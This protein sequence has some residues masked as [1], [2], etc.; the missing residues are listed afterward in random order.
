[1]SDAQSIPLRV[2][3]IDMKSR[4]LDLVVPTYLPARDL[5][6]RVARDAG[7]QAYWPD[8]RR[9]RFWIRARGR[10]VGEDERLSDVG[11]IAHELVHLLPEPP[12]GSVMEQD[13][14]YPQTQGYPAS[15]TLTV[16]VGLLSVLAWSAGWGVALSAKPGLWALLLPGLGL[17]LLSCSLARHVL[18]GEGG[19]LSI[20]GLGLVVAV[21]MLVPAALV[22]AL[23]GLPVAE[24][25]PLI[26][27]GAL[28]SVLGV[29]LG[30]LAW[31]GPVEPLPAHAPKVQAS[32][33]QEQPQLQCAICGMGVTQDV[34]VGCQHRCGRA[35]HK[36]CYQARMSVA[37]ADP[38]RC[39][40]CGAGL[41]Q[42][43]G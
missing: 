33:E 28:V 11:V 19:R 1:M 22:P 23:G 7:L 38:S 18:G 32:Q 14:D 5:T 30:W 31:W 6:Q 29:V 3:V 25:P 15:G 20:A 42:Q 9:R 26:L 13:P 27:P 34:A 35:F 39:G 41:G 16:V 8:G 2:Q 21:L 24:L 4:T 43:Q 17:G 36:G 40:I 10:V 12:D 37:Q